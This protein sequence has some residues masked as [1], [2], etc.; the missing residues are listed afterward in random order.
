MKFLVV[1]ASIIIYSIYNT[2]GHLS[3]K[4][5]EPTGL[6]Y[7][8]LRAMRAHQRAEK[9]DRVVICFD[10][11][12]PVVKASEIENYK[13]NRSWDGSK[14]DMYDQVPALKHML[15][16]TQYDQVEARG[17]EADDCIA[18]V[19]ARVLAH[20]PNNQV[21]ILSSD[22]D[23]CQLIGPRCYA[24]DPGTKAIKN[25]QWVMDH[26]SVWPAQLLM[27]RAALGDVSDN[28]RGALAGR[29]RKELLQVL[30]TLPRYP[31]TPITAD[32]IERAARAL[33]LKDL[34][35]EFEDPEFRENLHKNLKVMALHLP[36]NIQVT[37]GIGD[38]PALEA[39]FTQMEFNPTGNRSIWRHLGDFTGIK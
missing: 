1:D 36:P 12:G 39:L 31:Q 13:A 28:L 6:R 9:A 16:L 30:L 14:Q 3:T 38:R 26:F 18:H 27:L 10:S 22:N 19:T 21:C 24:K 29:M 15:E 33:G 35:E 17:Y 23:L 8:F 34:R 5:G 4:A 37:K 2:I 25:E 32:M 11:E 7:G 20:S